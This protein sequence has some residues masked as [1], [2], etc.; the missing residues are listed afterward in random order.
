[1]IDENSIGAESAE[2]GSDLR[3]LLAALAMIAAGIGLW[4]WTDGRDA[5]SS[6]PHLLLAGQNR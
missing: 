3:L 5:A 2:S 6:Q 4:A 1:M